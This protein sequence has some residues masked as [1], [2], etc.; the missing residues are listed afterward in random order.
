MDN[1]VHL[2]SLLEIL[3]LPAVR[4]HETNIRERGIRCLGLCCL[5][6]QQLAIENLLLFG[7]CYAKG[8]ES[9]QVIAIKIITDIL[10]VHGTSVLDTDGGVDTMSIYKMYYRTVRNPDEPE[11]QAVAAESL[12]KLLLGHVFAEEDLVKTLVVVY[13][14]GSSACNT[15]LR[16]ILNFCLPVY[17]YS[18]MES[19]ARL[20]SVVV[21]SLRR[22]TIAY[23]QSPDDEM[24][25]PTQI[26]QQLVDWTDPQ[27][28]VGYRGDQLSECAVHVQ[29]ASDMLM[30][31]ALVDSKNERRALCSGLS[32]L[33]I[34]GQVALDNLQEAQDNLLALSE[35][36]TITDSV[37]RN[38]LA[39]FEAALAKALTTAKQLSSNNAVVATGS[40]ASSPRST[41]V[42]VPPVTSLA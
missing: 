1:N 31:L 14:E 5:L 21:D 33:R 34:S 30:R 15:A 2:S 7:Q 3:V 40:V 39:R 37:S 42:S 25:S 19:Q 23:E 36:G 32:K 29:L 4:N 12:C 24:V 11:L 38:A 28:L 10:V 13:F 22:L 41:L 27:K 6:S 17:S 9:L 8:H 16:Q 18:S 20:G 35:S 26:I